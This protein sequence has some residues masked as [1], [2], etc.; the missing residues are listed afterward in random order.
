MCDLTFRRGC[1][2]RMVRQRFIDGWSLITCPRTYANCGQC[3]VPRYNVGVGN[4]RPVE[5]TSLMYDVFMI[6]DGDDGLCVCIFETRVS[7]RG[8]EP[9]IC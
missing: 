2:A 6:D 3:T 4:S 1:T 5:R 8:E 7:G 9:V